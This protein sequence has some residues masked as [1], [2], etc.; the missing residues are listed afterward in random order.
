[1]KFRV[2]LSKAATRDLER[3]DEITKEKIFKALLIIGN[4]FFSGK[5][6]QGKLKG[7]YSVR[8]WPFRIIYIVFKKEQDVLVISIRHR[9]DSV[10]LPGCYF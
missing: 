5:K 1:M 2:L 9:Q 3:I 8:V 10:S 4:D 7:L 6:L